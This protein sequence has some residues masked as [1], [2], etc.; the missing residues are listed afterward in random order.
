MSWTNVV[1]DLQP[2]ESDQDRIRKNLRDAEGSGSVRDLPQEAERSGER[3]RRLTAKQKKLM[4]EEFSARKKIE[5]YLANL[6]D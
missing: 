2:L 6:S 5:N 1:A 4:D 3:D